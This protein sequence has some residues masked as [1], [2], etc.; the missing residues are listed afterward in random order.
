MGAWD[1]PLADRGEQLLNVS[2]DWVFAR[3]AFEIVFA[4]PSDWLVKE[5]KVVRSLDVVA[6]RLE[7]PDDYVA[8]AVRVSD[9]AVGLEH[10]P[11]RQVAP[12]FVL[13]RAVDTQDVID[14]Q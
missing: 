8:M 1:E 13:M 9:R 2:R 5:R 4:P 3:R 10:E 11:L 12:A 6:K 7:R 14:V